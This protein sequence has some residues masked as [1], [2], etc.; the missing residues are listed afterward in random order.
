MVKQAGPKPRR[1]ETAFE[2][3]V[4]FLSVLAHELRNP[5]APLR[6]AT[7]VLRLICADPLQKHALDIVD[8]QLT[9]LTR[10]VDE[11]VDVARFR[12]G[13][14]TLEKQSVDVSAVVEQALET[15]HPLSDARQ[16]HVL[17]GDTGPHRHNRQQHAHFSIVGYPAG[18]RAA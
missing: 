8:R 16:Q 4:E 18:H 14:V 17:R 7:E 15:T 11:L 9:Q 3:S 12:R 1:F 2:P 5:I 13:L 6:S 10:L